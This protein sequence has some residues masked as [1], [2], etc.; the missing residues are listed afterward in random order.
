MIAAS[1]LATQFLVTV[2][3]P[4]RREFPIQT[5][6]CLVAYFTFLFQQI[7][8]HIIVRDGVDG[9][10]HSLSSLVSVS[11]AAWLRQGKFISDQVA[12]LRNQKRSFIVT[13]LYDATKHRLRMGE[14]QALLRPCALYPILD[15]DTW[16][17]VSYDEFRRCM[18]Q[19]GANLWCLGSCLPAALVPLSRC[20]RDHK[21]LQA[22]CKPTILENGQT[23]TVHHAV[24][25]AVPLS[26]YKWNH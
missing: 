25:K 10:C 13:R 24:E 17:L 3:G 18:G 2:R 21:W 15:G 6:T 22:L 9:S 4:T 11:Q 26:V 8:K 7:G 19:W 16:R 5:P 12:Y 1:G 20:G 23:S 14:L